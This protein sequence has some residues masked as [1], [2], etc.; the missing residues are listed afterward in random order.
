[1]NM[2]KYL[3]ALGC[4]ISKKDLNGNNL[5]HI[6]TIYGSIEILDYLVSNH[7]CDVFE[8]NNSGETPLI[9]AQS[10]KNKEAVDILSKHY[11]ERQ[12]KSK[13]LFE[14]LLSK[15]EAEEAKK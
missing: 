7:I 12:E 14:E 1:M 13:E 3:L 6:A 15:E 4:K 5:L 10:L 9:I 11:E 8:R 2:V